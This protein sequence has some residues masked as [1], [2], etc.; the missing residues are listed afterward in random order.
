MMLSTTHRS[1]DSVRIGPNS[2]VARWVING[3]PFLARE[4]NAMSNSWR[5]DNKR[6][7]LIYLGITEE[8]ARENADRLNVLAA[9]AIMLEGIPNT[10]NE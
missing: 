9:T 6:K 3:A 7:E 8:A 4:A 10:T 5:V 2:Y 1:T